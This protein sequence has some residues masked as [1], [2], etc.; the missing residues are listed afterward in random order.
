MV[1]VSTDKAEFCLAIPQFGIP[2]FAQLGLL[3]KQCFAGP[4]RHGIIKETILVKLHLLTG[5]FK[6]IAH[7]GILRHPQRSLHAND[8]L[9]PSGHK[10]IQ[11]LEVKGFTTLVHKG[12]NLVFQHLRIFM[13]FRMLHCIH[14][15]SRRIG[16]IKV[17][18]TG[19]DKLGE[20]NVA[21]LGLNDD[22]I[23]LQPAHQS[24]EL[25]QLFRSHQIGLIQNQRRA[26]LDLLN[27][28]ALNIVFFYIAG[29]KSFSAVELIVHARAIDHG[30]DIVKAYVRVLGGM[31]ALIAECRDVVGDGDRLTDAGRLDNDVIKLPGIGQI[32]KLQ[33]K[34]I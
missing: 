23:S 26:K 17:K 33:G 32:A 24:L 12:C 15:C 18:T 25:R 7:I 10:L 8:A 30:N 6:H 1:H 28:K 19:V 31:L 4:R 5:L 21:I 9:G 16:L 20:R 27:Q 11:F 22:R 14:P 34:V 2:V 29:E 13:L 3:V